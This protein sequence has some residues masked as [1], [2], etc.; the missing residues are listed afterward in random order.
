[1]SSVST[2]ELQITVNILHSTLLVILS[3]FC[4]NNKN[5]IIRLNSCASV[6]LNTEKHSIIYLYQSSAN[7]IGGTAVSC[8]RG[9]AASLC[10]L[11]ERS[12]HSLC[13]FSMTDLQKQ[14]KT[15]FQRHLA[16]DMDVENKQICDPGAQ[17]QS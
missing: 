15:Y 6:C 4:S 7:Q 12:S 10:A 5:I 14:L 9:W 8:D 17:N 2:E 3:S 13:I 1:M 16:V 11:L